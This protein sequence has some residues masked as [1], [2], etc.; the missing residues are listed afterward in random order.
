[1]KLDSYK[2][3]LKIKEEKVWWIKRKL[4]SFK[5]SLKEKYDKLTNL[6]TNLINIPERVKKM[7]NKYD[8]SENKFKNKEE[9]VQL[10]KTQSKNCNIFWHK[11]WDS[12]KIKMPEIQIFKMIY[13]DSET[14]FKIKERKV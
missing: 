6:I 14:N 4:D 5:I 8:S 1:M 9:K 7:I 12:F 11:K 3:W 10:M 2:I 13:K